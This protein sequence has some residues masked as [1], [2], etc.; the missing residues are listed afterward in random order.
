MYF[1]FGN[2]IAYSAVR[3][4]EMETVLK[5]AFAQRKLGKTGIKHLGFH[6]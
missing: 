5:P 6:L 1:I 4:L 2:G 3:F